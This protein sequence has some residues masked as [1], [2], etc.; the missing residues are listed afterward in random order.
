MQIIPVPCI[1]YCIIGDLSMYAMEACL[2]DAIRNSSSLLLEPLPRLWLRT[3]SR[4][5][6]LTAA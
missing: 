2:V 1:A 5:P 6:F 4:F 3:D